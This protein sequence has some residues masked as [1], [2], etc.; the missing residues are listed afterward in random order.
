MRS[1]FSRDDKTGLGVVALAVVVLG[2]V[3]IN[4]GW[5]NA[6][7]QPG[8]KVVRAQ[9][10]STG[11]L[12]KNDPVRIDGV[13]VGRVQELQLDPG[14]RTATVDMLLQDEARP[15]YR[16]ARASIR[17]RTALGGNFA[18]DLK[19]GTRSAG[20]LGG[21]AIPMSHTTNQVEV[22]DVIAFD[23]GASK[24]GFRTLLSE[25]P[26]VLA[27]P[28]QPAGLAVA[29][30][31]AAPNVT[32][33]ISAIRGQDEA[34]LRPLIESTAR[35]VKALDTPTDE[36]RNVVQG[37]AATV[38]T[39]AAREQDLRSTLDEGAAVQPAVQSTLVHLRHTLDIADPVVHRLRAPAR[40]IAPTLTQLRPTIDRADALLRAA[41]P[42][43]NRLDPAVRSLASVAR[44]G[45][46]LLERL[47]PGI[48]RLVETVLPTLAQKD[49]VTKQAT[50]EMI[51]PVIASLDSAASTFDAE[52]HL[53]RFPALGG[54]RALSDDLSCATFL[55]DPEASAAIQ[56]ATLQKAL[57]TYTRM[58][59]TPGR[60]R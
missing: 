45:R 30:R 2:V 35:T 13:E 33:A 5:L 59:A 11:Q 22:E 1:L 24:Q 18:I 20:E 58:T 4:T 46:P 48:G 54:Q 39:T 17:F 43:L 37:A 32:N 3:A 16:D 42:L 7:F 40:Q 55:T 6:Q 49:K 26:H 15:V 47:E 41:R 53:F 28:R 38:A 27:T 36:I 34:D 29:L 60:H 10:A 44:R 21:R 25:V 57:K 56:C 9:F 31:D 14:G 52:G 12:K 51:G 23:Q 8:G 50:Y 19:R